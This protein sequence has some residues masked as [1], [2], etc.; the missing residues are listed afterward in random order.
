[1]GYVDVYLFQNLRSIYFTVC[2]FTS[3]KNS[4]TNKNNNEK[5]Q[6]IGD[7]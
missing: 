2:T 7:F 3:I 1:M 6:E 5:S 4:N